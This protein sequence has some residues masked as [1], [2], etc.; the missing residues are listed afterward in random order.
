[1]RKTLCLGVVGL[2][3]LLPALAQAA[4]K[5]RRHKPAPVAHHAKPTTPKKKAEPKRAAAV[6]EPLHESAPA[7]AAEAPDA[8]RKPLVAR[9][10]SPAEP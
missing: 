6:V 7:P 9:A 4:A 2:G 5:T 8:P 10:A 1:M 3:L